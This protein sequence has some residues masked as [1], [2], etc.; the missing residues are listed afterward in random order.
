MKFGSEVIVRRGGTTRAPGTPG[1]KRTVRGILI[2]ALGNE[3]RVR[4][5]D[6]DPLDTVGWRLAGG[7]GHW[8]KSAVTLSPKPFMCSKCDRVTH[9]CESDPGQ[10]AECLECVVL[11]PPK[12]VAFRV[13][14]NDTER[15]PGIVFALTRAKARWA[16]IRLHQEMASMTVK[17]AMKGLLIRREGRLDWAA[18]MFDPNRCFIE[19]HVITTIQERQKG[20]QK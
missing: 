7:V 15:E 6:D 5:Y 9:G 17:E 16:V 19:E 13:T 20:T 10:V 11:S 3:Y 8:S 4:L 18:P 12:P 2:G 14:H 1:C